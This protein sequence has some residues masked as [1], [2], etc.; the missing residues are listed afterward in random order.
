[1]IVRPNESR[2]STPIP[3]MGGQ[4]YLPIGVATGRRPKG[5]GQCSC[6]SLCKSCMSLGRHCRR[7]SCSPFCHR[8]YLL[9][10]RALLL[11]FFAAM[12]DLQPS[13]EV[14]VSGHGMSLDAY[15]QLR[16]TIA[17]E[18]SRAKIPY[19][20]VTSFAPMLHDAG[21]VRGVR[22]RLVVAAIKRA[23]RRCGITL[24]PGQYAVARIKDVSGYIRY[25]T[26][27]Q[28][29]VTAAPKYYRVFTASRSLLPIGLCDGKSWMW[30]LRASHPDPKMRIGFKP[31]SRVLDQITWNVQVRRERYA[32]EA[33]SLPRGRGARIDAR[34]EEGV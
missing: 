18:L 16:R 5:D 1:M 32:D 2:E 10:V 17:D 28:E 25:L 27:G 22:R 14:R 29:A 11:E 33:E 12:P 26:D 19:G 30:F 31:N 24:R 6:D 4:H 7:A 34:R 3:S 23:A 8:L 9:D 15:R 13:L 20:L 21:F